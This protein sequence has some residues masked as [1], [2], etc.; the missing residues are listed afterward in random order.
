LVDVEVVADLVVTPVSQVPWV[1][2]DLHQLD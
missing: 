2:V 1:V